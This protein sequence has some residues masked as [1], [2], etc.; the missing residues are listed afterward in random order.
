MKEELETI[1]KDIQNGN[2]GS[3]RR[4]Q[5]REEGIEEIRH[6]FDI[7]YLMSREIRMLLDESSSLDEKI[8][9][10]QKFNDQI[11]GFFNY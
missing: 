2:G 8:M 7:D 6:L 11:K 5:R 4:I 3:L 10:L 1:L 9:E